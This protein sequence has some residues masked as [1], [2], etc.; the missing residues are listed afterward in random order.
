M[1]IP[2][3]ENTKTVTDLREDVVKILASLQK[4]KGP[5][6][7]FYRSKPKAVLLAIGEYQ[8]LLELLEDYEDSLE[9]SEVI[10]EAKAKKEK[11]YS[12]DQVAKMVDYK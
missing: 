9:A 8:R 12:F 10:A 5:Q 2:T 4:Q 7:V 11:L 3:E 6:F 1:I